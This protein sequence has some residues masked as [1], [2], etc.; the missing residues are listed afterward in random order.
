MS[1]PAPVTDVTPHVTPTITVEGSAIPDDMNQKLV[2]TVVDTHLH[3]PDM[4]EITIVDGDNSALGMFS[5]GSHVEIFGGAPSDPSAK[6]LIK[7]EVTSIEGEYQSPVIHTIIRG[8]EK[9]HRMQRISHTRVFKDM[10]DSDIATQIAGAYNF[11]D[12]AVDDSK[13]THNHVS[14]LDQTDWDFLK[15]RASEIGFE[16]G[17][18]GGSFFFR[19]PSGSADDSGGGLGGALDAAASMATGAGSPPT[20]TFGD[21][22]LYLR[23]RLSAGGMVSDVEVRVWDPVAADVVTSS[24]TVKSATATLDNAPRPDEMASMFGEE[25]PIPIPTLPAVPKIPGLKLPSLGSAPSAT[26]R[27]ICDRP[28]DQDSSAT[29]AA[30]KAAQGVAEHVASTFAEAEGSTYGNPDVQ[31]GRPVQIDGVPDEFKG[32]WIVTNAR[33]T[34]VP[35]EGGYRTDFVISGRHDRSFLGLAS[36]GRTNGPRPVINGFVCGIVTNN[37]DPKNM[38]RVKVA[39]PVFSNAYESDWARVVQVGLGAD[40]GAVFTPEVHDE[41]LV[42]FEFGDAR[43]PYVLGGLI[44]GNTSNDILSSAVKAT[45]M[46]AKVV[47]RGLVTP[48][49]N[50]IVFDDDEMQHGVQMPPPS[51]SSITISD[52]DGKMMVVI[53]KA[54]SKLQIVAEA[55]SPAASP[56]TITI[57]QKG[58]GGSISIK[59]AGNINIEAGASG[60]LSLKGGMG[61][62]IDG[63]TGGVAV[64]GNM[65]TLG[66]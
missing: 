28:V 35:A 39:F 37:N 33:H 54:N 64:K 60:Q 45:G 65:I 4:F 5:I 22:L 13:V 51:K 53:D 11:Q 21:N 20:L 16:V 1:L 63:G 34:F 42:G 8:Y 7:G 58:V 6:S 36:M 44:N 32:K 46:S 19:K 56:A 62:S 38:G 10:K 3:L 14:Q 50:R 66:S 9:A 27:V 2:Q 59:A 24:T 12:M 40:W 48:T 15:F 61:V 47:Q 41:V 29:V 31:A 52:K 25:S 30:D 17:V 55:G 18:A 49:G 23:P 26:A 43:R 57:E